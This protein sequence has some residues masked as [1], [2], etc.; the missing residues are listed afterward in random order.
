MST[1][2]QLILLGDTEYEACNAVRK[3]FF[4]MFDELG[5]EASLF[6]VYAG[7]DKVMTGYQSSKPA[8]AY[9]FCEAI[10][11]EKDK[12]AVESLMGNADPIYP[13]H[14]IEVT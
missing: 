11:G 7:E 12:L 13:V 4:E 1:L 3:H 2:Y 5:L 8:F 6:S 14:F 9:Y 10:H